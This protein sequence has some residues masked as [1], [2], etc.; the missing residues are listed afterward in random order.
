M[1]KRTHIPEAFTN[2]EG[3]I[4]AKC[5]CG[6]KHPQKMNGRFFTGEIDPNQ[7]YRES[8]KTIVPLMEDPS[9]PSDLIFAYE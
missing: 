1:S 9:V 5:S 3:H 2:H 7:G 4:L 6:H 8:T